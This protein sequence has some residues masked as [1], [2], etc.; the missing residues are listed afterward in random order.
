[1]P[2]NAMEIFNISGRVAALGHTYFRVVCCRLSMFLASVLV[3]VLHPC[4]ALA[5]CKLLRG[6][7]WAMAAARSWGGRISLT[8]WFLYAFALRCSGQTVGNISQAVWFSTFCTSSNEGGKHLTGTLFLH[9][10]ACGNHSVKTSQDHSMT[11]CVFHIRASQP[12]SMWN[13]QSQHSS[14]NWARFA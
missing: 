14:W 2:W 5:L 6:C 8:V 7:G 10:P 13:V 4:V 11:Q 9:R 3:R 1:M 12:R